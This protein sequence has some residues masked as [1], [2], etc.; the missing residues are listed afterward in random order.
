MVLTAKK[1]DFSDRAPSFQGAT[2][3]DVDI[4]SINNN[5]TDLPTW[6]RDVLDRALSASGIRMK[7]NVSSQEIIEHLENLEPSNV[8]DRNCPICFEE[9]DE[10][11][12]IKQC[13]SDELKRA[14]DKQ[15]LTTRSLYNK[16]I[17]QNLAVC[18]NL[19]EMY[20]VSLEPLS[21]G[22]RFND[23]SLFLPVDETASVHSRFPVRNLRTLDNAPVE[24]QYPGYTE[25]RKRNAG[26]DDSQEV[27]HNPVKMPTCNHIFGKSCITEWLREKNTCPL[28][29]K[30]IELLNEDDPHSIKMRRMKNIF[31]NFNTDQASVSDHL[32][33]HLT[34]ACNI[35]RRPFNP[36]V[37]P[38]TD[39]YMLQDWTGSRNSDDRLID[40]VET[41][42]PNLIIPRRSALVEGM[43]PV[44]VY[45]RRFP[46]RSVGRDSDTNPQN[47]A[48]TSAFG[49]TNNGQ[50]QQT[51]SVF[52][53]LEQ[54]NETRQEEHGLL[55]E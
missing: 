24:Q 47:T 49:S 20:N 27:P 36:F 4:D 42:D 11:E 13:R 14:A 17:E 41:P 9:Y 2:I 39:S 55:Q 40:R 22:E 28:C 7:R 31:Y 37:T 1:M 8:A 32:L 15:G 3:I 50:E 10:E 33:N 53:Q 21:Q 35:S 29:R 52:S 30:E 6:L 23:P 46:M 45:S 44:T 25:E 51:G 34:D 43:S 19:K 38:L 18:E 12:A 5:N 48:M 26:D 54:P 16:S